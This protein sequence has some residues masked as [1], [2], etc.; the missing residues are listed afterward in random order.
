MSTS[1]DRREHIRHSVS[2]RARIALEDTSMIN[3]TVTNISEGGISF[4]CDTFIPTGSLIKIEFYFSHQQKSAKVRAAIK[5]TFNTVMADNKGAQIGAIF[6]KIA[7]Q[8]EAMLKKIV[9]KLED[10]SKNGPSDSFGK[11]RILDK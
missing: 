10:Q 9:E 11:L 6:V 3:A 2:W 7:P 5:V 8:Y 1:S 4:Q